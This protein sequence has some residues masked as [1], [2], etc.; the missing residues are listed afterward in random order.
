MKKIIVLLIAI[1][2]SS[3]SFGQCLGGEDY[4]KEYF[5]QNISS[6]DPIE[7]I[8]NCTT[9]GK[10]YYDGVLNGDPSKNNTEFAIIKN[11]DNYIMCNLNSTGKSAYA[12]FTLTATNG[13]Y[14]F[15]CK[16]NDILSIT[17]QLTNG[18][19][20]EYTYEDTWSEKLMYKGTNQIYHIKMIDDEHLIKIYPNKDDIKTT[21]GNKQIKLEKEGS[22]YYITVKIG[23]MV[24]KFVLDSGASEINISEDLER[25][26]ILDGIITK[27][28][29]LE[30]G[31]YKTAN[32]IQEC[33]RV[34][35]KNVTVG[36]YTISNVAASISNDNS[37]ILLGKS[38]LDRF[39]KWSI[40]N[41]KSELILEN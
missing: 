2:I 12:E 27:S 22:V 35:L 4:Y 32:G 28:D 14:L 37:P 9:T 26:L 20:L 38:F 41:D 15:N 36:P 19:L 24:R 7:G 5:K 31:T 8:W 39:K 16:Q 29:Y 6:L 10:T 40:D 23:S 18:T 3:H 21:N 25:E 34:M 17:A 11:G 33:R 1:I 13:L 30:K